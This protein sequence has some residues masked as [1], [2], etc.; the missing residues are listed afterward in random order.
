MADEPAD[1]APDTSSGVW[2][3]GES[4]AGLLA[5][6]DA[7]GALTE[8]RLPDD[9]VSPRDV[10]VAPDGS[11]W[12]AFATCRL[13]RITS[14]SDVSTVPAPVPAA[15]LGFDPAGTMW[16]ASAARLVRVAP[17]ESVPG[18]C[19]NRVPK[20]RL[21]RVRGD[22]G[23]NAT[24]R[25][26]AEVVVSANYFDDSD[27]T[28]TI[29]SDRVRRLRAARGGTVRYPVPLRQRRRFRRDLAAGRKRT[30]S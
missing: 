30:S 28:L 6:V 27:G 15:E 26:P 4:G 20:V 19:D 24:V 22:L 16:L 13:A 21:R 25:E 12:F 9:V 8:A 5:H 18:G 11:A 2:V 14:A 1:L 7:A 17:G 3:I 10:A 29:G 23:F